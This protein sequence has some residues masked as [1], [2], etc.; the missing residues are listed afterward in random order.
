MTHDKYIQDVAGALLKFSRKV[1]W[2]FKTVLGWRSRRGV[3]FAF[4]GAKAL[5][6]QKQVLVDGHSYEGLDNNRGQVD[7]AAQRAFGFD[8]EMSYSKG[9]PRMVGGLGQMMSMGQHLSEGELIDGLDNILEMWEEVHGYK[10]EVSANITFLPSEGQPWHPGVKTVRVWDQKARRWQN[11]GKPSWVTTIPPSKATYRRDGDE[12]HRGTVY[13]VDFCQLMRVLEP[14]TYC[15]RWGGKDL[16]P[17]YTARD[18]MASRKGYVLAEDESWMASHSMDWETLRKARK[19]LADCGG[20]LFPSLAL[21][22]VPSSNYGPISFLADIRYVIKSLKTACGP[23]ER[24]ARSFTIYNTDTWT[25]TTPT[26]VTG[27]ASVE[28]FEQLTGNWEI[29]YSYKHLYVLGPREE[30]QVMMSRIEVKVFASADAMH[31]VMAK[32]NEHYV[33]DMTG[34]DLQALRMSAEDQAYPYL[35]A[36]ANG[37]LPWEAFGYCLVPKGQV[38]RARNLLRN[39]GFT[40]TVVE[41]PVA[42]P[43]ARTH[44]AEP[45]E[46]LA[47]WQYGWAARETLLSV[48]SYE[49]KDEPL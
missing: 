31:R 26:F 35:E 44:G 16:K 20:F 11:F 47:Q 8:A 33:R 17:F 10:T 2:P 27:D 3:T 7:V 43:R 30:S 15:N 23:K 19:P 40:G 32:R 14:V 13:G 48:L 24:G 36:K 9:W 38:R 42:H 46:K 21:G 45:D 22:P 41:V 18:A 29:D 28:A 6:I 12:G 4:S 34:E 1:N 5:Q 49:E 39:T 37:I 25:E